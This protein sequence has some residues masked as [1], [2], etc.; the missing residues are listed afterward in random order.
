MKI[1]DSRKGS[2]VHRANLLC[3]IV[4]SKDAV[5]GCIFCKEDCKEGAKKSCWE[6]AFVYRNSSNRWSLLLFTWENNCWN[7]LKVK[8]Y[9]DGIDNRE[10]A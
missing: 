9:R 1:Q 6:S 5:N 8:S 10:G 3:D 7:L 4:D 2:E